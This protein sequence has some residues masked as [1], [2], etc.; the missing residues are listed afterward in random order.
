MESAGPKAEFSFLNGNLIVDRESVRPIAEAFAEETSWVIDDN[1][2]RTGETVCF[3]FGTGHIPVLDGRLLDNVSDAI[4]I[5]KSQG[6]LN[7][8]FNP[9]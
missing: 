8:T 9:R 7:E 1:Q 5:L 3:I 6:Y 4:E 2:D